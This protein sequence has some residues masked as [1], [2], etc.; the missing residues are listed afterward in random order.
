MLRTA[1]YEQRG[2]TITNILS[3]LLVRMPS[4]MLGWFATD[5]QHGIYAAASRFFTSLRIV[6]GAVLNTIIPE[7]SQRS[8]HSARIRNVMLLALAA[9]ALCSAFL[10]FGAPL[11]ISYTFSYA[12]SVSI[13]Q[14]LALGFGA[15]FLKTTLEGFLLAAHKEHLVNSVLA[16]VTVCAITAY[17]INARLSPQNVA[18][19]ISIS[20]WVL[21][22][23]LLTIFLSLKRTSRNSAEEAETAIHHVEHPHTI[24]ES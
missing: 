21:F 3:S 13:L 15:L 1:F 19:T 5:A 20:E 6:P 9:A 23:A 16:V 2:V 22:L 18:W 10:Y 8:S 24:S 14:I 7:Y 17:A 12:E 4:I 11:L